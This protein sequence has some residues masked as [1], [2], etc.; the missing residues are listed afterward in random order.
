MHSIERHIESIPTLESSRM[1]IFRVLQDEETPIEHIEQVISS[2]PAMAA[3][4]I[5]LAYS[6]F[7]VTQGLCGHTPALRTIG[8][9]W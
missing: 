2:D 3:K 4:V 8:M 1:R 6:A 5:K 7:T 9:V